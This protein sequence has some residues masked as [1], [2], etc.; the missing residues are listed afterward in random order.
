MN[1][2]TVQHPTVRVALV[3][4]AGASLAQAEAVGSDP[5]RFPPLDAT[6]FQTIAAMKVKI[7]PEL[8]E[9]AVELL[10]FNPFLGAAGRPAP[11]MEEFFKDVFYDFVSDAFDLRAQEAFRQLIGAYTTVLRRSTN[12][13]AAAGARGPILQLITKAAAAS[14]HLLLASLGGAGRAFP[15]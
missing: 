10:G 9:Y 8:T 6:F 7:A 11:G 2:E 13:V 3:I 5:S 4:G 15:R 1:N 14:S 12:E